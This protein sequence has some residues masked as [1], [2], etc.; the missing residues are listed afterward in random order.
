VN[1]L[2]N[3]TAGGLLGAIQILFFTSAVLYILNVFSVPKKN[4][5]ESSFLYGPVYSLIPSTV[6]FVGSYTPYTN[7]KKAVKVINHSK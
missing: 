7:E 1:N 4:I 2:I 6:D 5:Q 3:Q